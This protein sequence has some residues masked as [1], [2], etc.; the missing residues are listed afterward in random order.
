VATAIRLWQT[1]D[2]DEITVDAIVEAAGVSKGTFYYHFRRKEDILVDLGWTT[3]DRVGEEAEQA[4]QQGFSLDEAID[5]GMAGLAR[6]IS[7]MPRGAVARTIQEFIF[8]RPAA[9]SSRDSD[10]HAFLSGL[11]QVAQQ[12]GELSR[13]IDTDEV[14]RVLN[15]TLIHT[16]LD[17]VTG[18]TT[19]PLPAALKRRARLVLYGMDAI[20][21]DRRRTPP[22]RA[23]RPSRRRA[24]SR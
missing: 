6:R 10:R 18:R 23:T 20:Y 3:V 11:L 1:R 2:F 24:K 8:T 19:E 14:A 22:G 12:S 13:S 9:P 7:S 17:S 21:A 5:L 16:I 15:Y 4:Y